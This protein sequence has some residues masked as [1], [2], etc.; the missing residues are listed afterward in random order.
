MKENKYTISEAARLLSV[1]NHVLRY[2]EEELELN[3]PRNEL[4]HRYYREEEIQLLH[5]IKEL[6]NKGFQL[7]AVKEVLPDLEQ[8]KLIDIHK[9]LTTQEELEKAA[10][11]CSVFGRVT[12]QQKKQLVIA[13]KKKGHSVAMT[14]DGVNDVLA[15]KEADCSIAMA[16]GS[17]AARNVSQLVLVNNDFASMPGVVAEG[18]RT[19]NNLE[20]SSALYIVKTIYTIIL[21]VFF[22]FFHMP[23]PFEPIHFSLV[24]ALTVGLPSF[25]LALQPNKNRIKGNFTYNIIARAVPA[26]FCTVLNIIGMAVI[27]KF[28]TLAPDEYSTICVY[29]TA[30]CAYMLILRLSYPFNALRI[31]MLTVSAVGIVLGCVFFAGFFSLVWLSVDGLILFGL[32]SAFTIVSFNLLYNY[33]EK[34]IEKNKNKYK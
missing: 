8:K 26:A 4:G 31:A 17:D 29:M 33:A 21:S 1:E 24:G 22:I 30:L 9:L 34:L 28:T 15:L 2:W 19:I 20:R 12:P 10:E 25:V 13:L 16:A 7:K 11:N 14:G 3:I 23:Y 18:R 27:T 6:K 32:L 5:C